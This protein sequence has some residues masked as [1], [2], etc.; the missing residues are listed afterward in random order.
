MYVGNLVKIK[1]YNIFYSDQSWHL[2]S[3]DSLI[4][5][6]LKSLS[7]WL[8]DCIDPHK[9][10]TRMFQYKIINNNPTMKT[11]DFFCFLQRIELITLVYLIA[12]YSI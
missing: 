1:I 3:T 12:L 4:E 2:W 6:W 8:H 10:W 7:Y 11:G 9:S 5:N